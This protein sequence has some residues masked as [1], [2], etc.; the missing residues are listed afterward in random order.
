[1]ISSLKSI[2]TTTPYHPNEPFTPLRFHNQQVSSS[3]KHLGSGFSKKPSI[4]TTHFEPENEIEERVFDWFNS[5]GL[6]IGDPLE[7]KASI[8]D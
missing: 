4:N 8:L 5:M 1:M 6:K 2:P 7:L 3:I